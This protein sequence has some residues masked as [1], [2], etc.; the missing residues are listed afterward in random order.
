[1]GVSLVR[2]WEQQI[3]V[4]VGQLAM[5]EPAEWWLTTHALDHLE[6]AI[7]MREMITSE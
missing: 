5:P 7:S 2:E 3:G 6:K 1:M 4:K